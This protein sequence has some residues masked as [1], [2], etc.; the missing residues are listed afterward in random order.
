MEQLRN[1]EDHK[2]SGQNTQQL[3]LPKLLQDV[4][5]FENVFFPPT[6]MDNNPMN[7]N[8][9]M[10]DFN[11]LPELLNEENVSEGLHFSLDQLDCTTLLQDEEVFENV[12]FPPTSMDNNPMAMD[13]NELHEILNEEKV[14][15]GVDFV[16]GNEGGQNGSHGSNMVATD[17]INNGDGLMNAKLT[18]E[19]NVKKWNVKKRLKKDSIEAAQARELH[20]IRNREAAARSFAEK[21]AYIEWLELEVQIFRKKNADLKKLLLFSESSLSLDMTRK[22]LKRTA[23]GPM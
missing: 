1:E 19:Q 4:E 13:F 22:Q 8:E 16:V 3:D 21:K 18:N 6:S 12:F 23:S 15:E 5:A 7:I 10:I 9:Y 17:Q 20:K 14:S 2:F 11:E